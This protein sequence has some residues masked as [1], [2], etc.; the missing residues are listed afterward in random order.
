MRRGRRSADGT[1]RAYP[2]RLVDIDC[3]R[4]ARIDS[5]C[6]DKRSCPVAE[7][8][9]RMSRPDSVRR[10]ASAGSSAL[11][12]DGRAGN[13]VDCQMEIIVGLQ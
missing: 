11:Q 8:L 7:E 9:C 2:Q 6:T 1:S 5:C 12:L 4:N 10:M 3:E 13:A